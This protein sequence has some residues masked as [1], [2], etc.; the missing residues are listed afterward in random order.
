M[1]A[2]RVAAEYAQAE[3]NTQ[4]EAQLAAIAAKPVPVEAD[5]AAAHN[6]PLN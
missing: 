6:A 1:N 2:I 4:I 5:L 3:I